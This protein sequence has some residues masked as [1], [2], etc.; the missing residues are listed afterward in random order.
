MCMGTGHEYKNVCRQMHWHMHRHVCRHMHRQ[1]YRHACIDTGIGLCLCRDMNEICPDR[2][3]GDA[4]SEFGLI[5]FG[6]PSSVCR[7]SGLELLWLSSGP[8]ATSKESQPS[9]KENYL[10]VLKENYLFVLKETYLFS[11]DLRCHENRYR[12]Q[13]GYRKAHN[14]FAP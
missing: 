4:Y 7:P 10:F 1:V 13:C 9:F 12:Y 3:H 14:L 8:E 6:S 11:R 5:I 2:W